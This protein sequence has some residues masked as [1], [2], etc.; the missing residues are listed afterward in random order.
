MSESRRIDQP[1]EGRWLV[2]LGRNRPLI[3]AAIMRV[4]TTSEPGESS[5]LMERSPFLAAF[6]GGEPVALYEVWEGKGTP[7]TDDEYRF[8]VAEMAWAKRYA[9]S[10]PIARPKEAVSLFDRPAIGPPGRK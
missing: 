1:Q 2:R 8:R 5:N 4:Q 9:P 6:I 10:E 3:P 7:I